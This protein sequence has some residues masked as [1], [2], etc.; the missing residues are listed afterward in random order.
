MD[1]PGKQFHF[2]EGEKEEIMRE[3]IEKYFDPTVL[4]SSTNSAR[5][6]ENTK[7]LRSAL[8]CSGTTSAKCNIRSMREARRSHTERKS[9]ASAVCALS[10][11]VQG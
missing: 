10:C 9:K 2:E 6:T 4:S 5:P 1:H 7:R 3:F 8:S 11:R